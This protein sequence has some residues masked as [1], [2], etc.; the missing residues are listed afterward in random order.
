MASYC[1][2]A[3]P[4]LM[5][6]SGNCTA[7]SHCQWFPAGAPIAV[8]FS[9]RLMKTGMVTM[10]SMC[11]HPSLLYVLV[12]MR[13]AHDYQPIPYSFLNC[14]V[15]SMLLSS[16]I[17]YLNA[18]GWSPESICD[19]AGSERIGGSSEPTLVG[20]LA[21]DRDP[22]H[23]ACSNHLRFY[24]PEFPILR[25]SDRILFVDDDV[26][27]ME[28]A[29]EG[30]FNRAIPPHALLTANCEVNLWN[31]G[32]QRF[33]MGTSLYSHFFAG[34]S[35]PPGSWEQMLDVVH[36]VCSA[37]DRTT[38][39]HSHVP[40][41]AA[42]TVLGFGSHVHRRIR[43]PAHLPP[44]YAGVEFWLQLDASGQAPQAQ[45]LGRV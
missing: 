41:P 3:S 44:D 24:L 14:R 5:C 13:V 26:V 43:G 2:F 32:C 42:A 28:D 9:D 39:D 18:I 35:Y 7:H 11:R 40:V 12:F 37:A 38:Y 8:I 21:W 30:L 16:A 29:V 17:D 31:N 6:T 22:K 33:D 10:T 1:D 25:A 15:V 20:A 4:G 36:G 45:L 19:P 23:A 27:I 34:A